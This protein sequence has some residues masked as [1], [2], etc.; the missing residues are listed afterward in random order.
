MNKCI[1]VSKNVE[2]CILWRNDFKFI[3]FVTDMGFGKYI[4]ITLKEV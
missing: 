4:G 2:F 3:G 1:R